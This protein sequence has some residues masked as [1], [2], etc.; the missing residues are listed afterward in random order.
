MS[1]FK[2][3]DPFHKS[4]LVDEIIIEVNLVNSIKCLIKLL[5]LGLCQ[6]IE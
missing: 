4:Y 5:D 2:I 3:I 1:D 6:F